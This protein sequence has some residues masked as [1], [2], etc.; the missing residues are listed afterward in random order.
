MGDLSPKNRK[1]EK[2]VTLTAL[3]YPSIFFF[4]FL[5]LDFAVDSSALAFF[6]YLFRIHFLFFFSN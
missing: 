5:S 3:M 6:L 1:K 4:F 2:Y